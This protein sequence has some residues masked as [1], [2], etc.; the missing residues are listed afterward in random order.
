MIPSCLS[1]F[2]RPLRLGVFAR[3]SFFFLL[4]K[5]QSR[6]EIVPNS[7]P[8][9][10]FAAC[11]AE[12]RVPRGGFFILAETQRRKEIV[13][14]S[15]CLPEAFAAWRLCAQFFFFCSR[16]DAEPAP[17]N[18]G[19]A[20]AD[21]FSRRDAETCLRRTGAKKLW[22]ARYDF[23]RPLRLGVFASYFFSFLF[24]QSLPIR[25]GGQ[26]AK[27]QLGQLPLD[28]GVRGII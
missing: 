17:Q 8:L 1:T 4:A 13:V 12:L 26:D 15:V 3:N 22:S 14:R 10:Y 25:R 24:S 11:P 19:S 23:R 20:A 7:L 6:K 28:K 18:C 2:R 21:F 27:S 16:Q 9:T 5:T